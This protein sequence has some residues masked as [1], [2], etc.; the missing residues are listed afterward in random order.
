M[1]DYFDAFLYFLI[2]IDDFR[3]RRSFWGGFLTE[4]P[5]NPRTGWVATESPRRTLGM[6]SHRCASGIVLTFKYT[7]LVGTHV[8]PFRKALLIIDLDRTLAGANCMWRISWRSTVPGAATIVVMRHILC[9]LFLEESDTFSAEVSFGSSHKGCD[10]SSDSHSATHVTVPKLQRRMKVRCSTL[11]KRCHQQHS[12]PSRR[13]TIKL[14]RKQ[15]I[16]Q[17]VL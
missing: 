7:R 15:Y 4:I 2:I 3:T 13:S 14:H 9:M 5:N 1:C 12:G 8:A 11:T 16:S 17:Q 10:F 6:A